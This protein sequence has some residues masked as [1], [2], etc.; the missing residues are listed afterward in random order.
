MTAEGQIDNFTLL[1]GI[2]FT[3]LIFGPIIYLIMWERR[4]ILDLKKRVN[5]KFLEKNKTIGQFEI[6]HGRVIAL[7]S[8]KGMLI[9][10]NNNRTQS[11]SIVDLKKVIHSEVKRT[12]DQIT[13]SFKMMHNTDALDLVLFDSTYDS[14]LNAGYYNLIANRWS[15]LINQALNRDKKFA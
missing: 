11:L 9:Y 12:N 15:L 5:D 14:I 10:L 4:G 6:W 7:D 8:T 13:L 3:L 2:I 1:M